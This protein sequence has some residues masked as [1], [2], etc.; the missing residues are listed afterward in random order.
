MDVY[1]HKRRWSRTIEREKRGKLSSESARKLLEN[2]FIRACVWRHHHDD[3]A[4]SA[5]SERDRLSMNEHQGRGRT[6]AAK[7]NSPIGYPRAKS[8]L[9]VQK[10]AKSPAL[11]KF[12]GLVNRS[13]NIT[14]A[15]NTAAL[16]IKIAMRNIQFTRLKFQ[17]FN[18]FIK[19]AGNSNWDDFLIYIPEIQF[20]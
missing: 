15:I 16:L 17:F 14:T 4:H 1:I 9:C 12:I 3:D 20:S 7:Q 10:M 8:L 2:R 19:L 11:E 18:V 5:Q 6:A 13:V